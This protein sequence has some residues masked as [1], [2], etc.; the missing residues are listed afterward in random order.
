MTSKSQFTYFKERCHYWYDYL[1]LHR[2]RLEVKEVSLNKNEDNSF[3][4][5]MV[6]YDPDNAVMFVFFNSKADFH[7]ENELDDTALHEVF[8]GCMAHLKMMSEKS[9]NSNLVAEKIHEVVN[10]VIHALRKK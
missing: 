7:G 10:V 9:F 3:Y 1:G 6:E 2:I 4:Y 8:E 5:A